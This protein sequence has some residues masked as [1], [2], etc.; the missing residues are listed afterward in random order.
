MGTLPS[1][2][3]GRKINCDICGDWHGEREGKI[4][5]Q[6]GLNVCPKCFDSLTDREREDAIQR[7]TR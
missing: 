1:W 2:Y 3:K 7:R 4:R 5:K 6:R